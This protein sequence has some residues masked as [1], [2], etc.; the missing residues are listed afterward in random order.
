M[1]CGRFASGVHG[2]CNSLTCDKSCT[3]SAPKTLMTSI[4]SSIVSAKFN[5]PYSLGTLY[6]KS[7]LNLRTHTPTPSTGH[8]SLSYS[9]ALHWHPGHPHRSLLRRARLYICLFGRQGFPIHGFVS[10]PGGAQAPHQVT[11]RILFRNV[12]RVL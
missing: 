1:L 11:E 7:F 6:S 9:H 5:L 2:S 10:P 12:W 4:L 3:N 8:P